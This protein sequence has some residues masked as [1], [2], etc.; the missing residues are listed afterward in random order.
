MKN[1]QAPATLAFDSNTNQLRI[2]GDWTIY[3]IDQIPLALEKLPEA[4]HTE[5]VLDCQQLATLDSAGAWEIIKIKNH[6]QQQQIALTLAN[7]KAN[8]KDLLTLAEKHTDEILNPPE[9]KKRDDL[10]TMVG[11]ESIT[12]F[13][14][15]ISFVAFIG[16]TLIIFWQTLLKPRQL[17]WRGFLYEIDRNGYRAT[18]IIA[19]LAF[20]IGVVL[21][22]QMGLQLKTYGA[23][24]YIVNLSGMAIL[25]EFGPLITAIIV[26]GRTGSS[27][28]AE[29]GLM[30]VN[31]EVDALETMGLSPIARLVLPKLFGLI[32]ALPLLTVWADLFGVFGS[33]VMAKGMLGVNYVDFLNRFPTVIML[34]DYMTGLV[35]APVFAIIIATV[36]CY[37]GLQVSMSSESVGKLT[38]KSVVQAIFLI[39][40]ADAIFSVIFSWLGL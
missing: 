16:E 31:E 7:I 26:A 25:R 33:M 24:I 23:N 13:H 1:T 37:Q 17:Q 3:T 10:L 15:L 27:F 2:A 11:K 35:K 22:Y 12:K 8:Q 6:F 34:S 20:L 21:A 36:G 39:V 4:K 32:I 30:K 19:L 29:I 40:I 18:P 9:P 28:T 14:E 38:T 5:L